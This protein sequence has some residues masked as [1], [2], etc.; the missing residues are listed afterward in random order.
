MKQSFKNILLSAL[1]LLA[2]AVWTGL[3]MVFDLEAI[4]PRG[5][6]VGFATLNQ[7]VHGLTG[8]HFGLYTITD[9]LGLVPIFICLIFAVIGAAQFFKSGF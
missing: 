5:S 4:G 8:V 2:F 3:I 1:L 6:V 7:F 9:W